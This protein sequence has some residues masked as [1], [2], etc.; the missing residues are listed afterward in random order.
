MIPK[1]AML[2]IT[3]TFLA[4]A[5]L[6]LCTSLWVHDRPLSIARYMAFVVFT[7]LWVLDTAL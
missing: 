2:S 1:A 6:M 4:L 3:L 5:M 7:S